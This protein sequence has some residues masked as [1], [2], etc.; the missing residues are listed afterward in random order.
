VA[1]LNI[2]AWLHVLRLSSDEC[3]LRA[4]DPGRW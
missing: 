3:S 4:G 2:A 1:D